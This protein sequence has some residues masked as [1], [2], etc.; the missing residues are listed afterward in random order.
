MYY[1]LIY[2]SGKREGESCG[3][4]PDYDGGKCL[5]ELE[6]DKIDEICKQKG[7]DIMLLRNSLSL[8]LTIIGSS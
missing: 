2:C 8:Q 6:F 1:V 7:N 3:N 4:P 5:D